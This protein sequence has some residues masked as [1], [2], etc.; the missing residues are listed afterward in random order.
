LNKNPESPENPDA[1]PP[2]IPVIKRT[3]IQLNDVSGRLNMV[4]TLVARIF[5]LGIVWINPILI[6]KKNMARNA[7]PNACL[8]DLAIQKESPKAIGAII[9]QGKKNCKIKETMAIISINIIFNLKFQPL[10]FI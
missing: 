1:S 6:H 8:P 2:I 5:S 3:I 9:H 4:P 7:E 10:F